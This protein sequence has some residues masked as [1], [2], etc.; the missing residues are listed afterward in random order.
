MD[1]KKLFRVGF[2]LFWAVALG[3]LVLDT[4]G[5]ASVR[6][7]PPPIALGSGQAASGGHCSGRCVRSIRPWERN[8]WEQ[9]SVGAALAAKGALDLATFAGKPAPTRAPSHKSPLPQEPAPKRAAPADC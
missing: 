9:L 7:E 2:A 6:V 1:N 8:S 5:S 3:L 4:A